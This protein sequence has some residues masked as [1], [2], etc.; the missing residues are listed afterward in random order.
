[1]LTDQR[2]PVAPVGPTVAALMANIKCELYKAANDNTPLPYLNDTPDLTYR[3][4][5]RDEDPTYYRSF[6][7]RNYFSEIEYVAVFEL[8]L[9]VVHT[10]G[11]NP[12]L[13]FI[14]PYTA[15]MTN[16]TLAVGGQVNETA[17]RTI[18]FYQTVD[19]QRLVPSPQ[20]S[21][22]A[23]NNFKPEPPQ[24]YSIDESTTCNRGTELAGDLGLRETIATAAITAR[25]EDVAALVDSGNKLYGGTAP[26]KLGGYDF[27]QYDA[28]I[29]FTINAGVNG[30]PNWTLTHFKGPAGGGGMGGG[31]GAGGMGGTGGGGNQ[32]LLNFNRQT[33]DTLT[34]SF[35]AVCIR[36][37][38]VPVKWEGAIGKLPTLQGYIGYTPRMNYGTPV[39]GNYLP[40]CDS[41]EGR[42][43][44]AAAPATGK[45]NVQIQKLN[46]L[47][48]RRY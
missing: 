29:I 45:S 4:F 9:E 36:Q 48:L 32:G 41:P 25:M 35:L 40:P 17:D 44:K 34:I 7:L 23:R 31:G 39:W 11:A 18:D 3:R 22:Y 16:F 10:T 28:N 8:S 20:N 38:Y 46:D 19:F 47:L 5:W 26:Q 12:S 21:W 37:K 14:T 2:L 30:G 27:G 13:N 33:K 24:Q 6:T 42:A 43:A 15:A 1:V